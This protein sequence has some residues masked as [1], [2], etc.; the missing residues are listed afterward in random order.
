MTTK[1]KSKKSQSKKPSNKPSK[2]LVPSNIA[3]AAQAATIAIAAVQESLPLDDD[4]TARARKSALGFQYVSTEAFAAGAAVLQKHGDL[5]PTI[6]ASEL[7]N[8]SQLETSLKEVAI[9]AKSLAQKVETT[10]LKSRKPVAEQVFFMHA[11]LKAKSKTD[12]TVLD[13]VNLLGPLVNT[14]PHPHRRRKATTGA[15]PN[16]PAVTLPNAPAAP[17]PHAP[18]AVENGASSASVG[19]ATPVNGAAKPITNGVNAPAVP[20]LS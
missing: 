7:R 3:A 11:T 17:A 10:I 5:F 18:A 14:R 2:K 15:T 12:G 8:I 13:A 20:L 1:V 9:A 16:A 4:L 6:D 19:N